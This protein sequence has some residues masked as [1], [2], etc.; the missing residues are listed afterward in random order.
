MCIVIPV[1]CVP[2]MLFLVCAGCVERRLHIRTEPEGAL[3]RVNGR[4]IGRSPAVWR[5]HHYGTVRVTTHLDGYL[6]EQREVR[7]KTP[8][9]EYPVAD[10]FSDV[11]IPTRIK[12]DHEV[13][14]TL[15]PRTESSKA[16]DLAAA[17]ELADRA[18]AL[19]D[20]MRDEMREELAEESDS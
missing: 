5:F 7:L 11:L 1:R 2:L 6:P 10:L 8:W 9:Y 13:S 20:E 16:E 18:A 17:D 3:V 19:R 14:I 12:D 15:Q 4:D